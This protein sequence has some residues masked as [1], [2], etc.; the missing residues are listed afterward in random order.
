MKN[1]FIDLVKKTHEKDEYGVQ[2]KRE[3]IIEDIPCE[4]RSASASEWFEG[5]RNGLNPE[6]TFLINVMDYDGEETVKYNGKRY[7]VYRT[8]I[9]GDDIEL[10]VQKEKG[11]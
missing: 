4:V 7:A 2:K 5:G 9:T 1:D 8:F 11:A 10:H 6:F 3:I